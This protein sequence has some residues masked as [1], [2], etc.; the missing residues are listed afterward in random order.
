MAVTNITLPAIIT[1]TNT[2][3]KEIRF[4]PY[5]ENFSVPVAAGD[6]YTLEA[7]TS[8]QVFYYLAQETEGLTVTQA[9]KAD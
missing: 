1:I 6:V 8:G 3:D 2:S 7:T 9:P 4:I 5:R